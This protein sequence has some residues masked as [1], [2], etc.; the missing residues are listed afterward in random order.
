[1]RRKINRIGL[2]PNDRMELIADI[3]L[4]EAAAATDKTVLSRDD[5]ARRILATAVRYFPDLCP[6]VWCNPV[7][8]HPGIIDWLKAGARTVRAWQLRSRI[9]KR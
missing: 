1:L 2:D 5:A 9:D 8:R 4:I 3:H 7:T 6:I